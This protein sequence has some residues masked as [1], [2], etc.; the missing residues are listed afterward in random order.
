MNEG[1]RWLDLLSS[2]ADLGSH[3]C[4]KGRRL[5]LTWAEVLPGERDTGRR[6]RIVRLNAKG[7]S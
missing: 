4:G 2:H 1:E 5:D 7:R 3:R 6:W